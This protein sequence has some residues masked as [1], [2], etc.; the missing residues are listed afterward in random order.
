MNISSH[1]IGQIRTI[2]RSGRPVHL[3]LAGA[4]VLIVYLMHTS[5]SFGL[6]VVP[7][8]QNKL[9]ETVHSIVIT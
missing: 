9:N 6:D 3:P 1:A 2:N 4:V 8:V 7:P 5:H